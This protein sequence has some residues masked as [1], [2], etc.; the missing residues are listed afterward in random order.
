MS[1]SA[2]KKS[3]L[4]AIPELSTLVVFGNAELLGILIYY[5]VQNYHASTYA[6]WQPVHGFAHM[7]CVP[8]WCLVDA[9]QFLE[10]QR[11]VQK[12]DREPG[13]SH[14]YATITLPKS[15]EKIN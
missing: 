8:S 5:G 2:A 1:H 6:E 11:W 13:I 4:W 10:S 7:C 14:G 15:M 3:D 9:L 12:I